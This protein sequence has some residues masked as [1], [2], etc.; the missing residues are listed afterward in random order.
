MGGKILYATEHRRPSSR[1]L[2]GLSGFRDIGFKEI[3]FLCVIKGQPKDVTPEVFEQWKEKINGYGLKATIKIGSGDLSDGVLNT[4]HENQ[5][6]FAVVHFDK[7]KRRILFGDSIVKKLIKEA[8]VPVLI[9]DKDETGLKFT[10]KG[11]FE[12][13][14]FATDWSQASEKA[15]QIILG[16]KQ[17][18]NELDIVNVIHKKLT[19]RELRQLMEKLRETRNKCLKEGIDAEYHVYAGKTVDEIILAAQDYNST[20]IVMGTTPGQSFKDIFTGKPSCSV[21]ERTP[22]PALLVPFR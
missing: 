22:I 4:I 19:V 1:V 8:S 18:I 15:L 6:S 12:R 11:A 9:V 21:V 16:F 10:S 20:S 2:E 17:L 3:I 13:V 5:I 14:L 7:K